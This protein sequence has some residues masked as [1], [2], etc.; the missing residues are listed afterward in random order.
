MMLTFHF[1]A[2]HVDDFYRG[3]FII[4]HNQYFIAICYLICISEVK[5]SIWT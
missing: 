5:I 3:Q 2:E 1:E 4:L